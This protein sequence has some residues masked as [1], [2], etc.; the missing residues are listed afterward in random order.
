M[1]KLS[2]LY[3][4]SLL[5]GFLLGACGGTDS[6]M[7]EPELMGK[8]DVAERVTILGSL[9]YGEPVS[10][11]FTEDIQFFAYTFKSEKGGEVKIEVTQ[12]GSS[13]GLDTTMFVYGPIDE[14][15][16]YPE[17]IADDND[18]GWGLLSK[19]QD[20]EIETTGQYLVVVGTHNGMGR[21]DY[22]LQLDCP[23]YLCK[24][25]EDPEEPEEPKTDAFEDAASGVLACYFDSWLS[26]T[27]SI[28]EEG[29]CEGS[30]NI[31]VWQDKTDRIFKSNLTDQ[32]IDEGGH[33]FYHEL[34]GSITFRQTVEDALETEECSF[35]MTAYLT[36]EDG[37][38]EVKDD[39]VCRDLV[40]TESECSVRLEEQLSPFIEDLWYMSEGD[41]PFEFFSY[42]TDSTGPI[43]PELVMKEV[44]WKTSTDY[45]H[46][47][48]LEE[49]LSFYLEDEDCPYEEDS[50]RYKAIV[51]ILNRELEDVK[52]V[53]IDDIEVK[54]F[55]I[56]R[57]PCGELAGLRTIAI[58]T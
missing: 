57:T 5:V 36:D 13:R 53:F 4:I 42:P 49:F 41:Y 32:V 9:D 44:L 14:N 15:G 39:L 22:G 23:N 38:I 34:T 28:D 56:G 52:A 20:L 55:I 31:N 10:G 6:Q 50:E 54:V 7:L 43:T 37:S 35:S 30:S 26:M 8:A 29:V 19:V 2:K 45:K 21:G 48:E 40:P 11:S 12:L 25:G 3:S 58:W 17:R 27:Y 16:N 33:S 1:N 24:E 46:T 18:S 47:R 51:E